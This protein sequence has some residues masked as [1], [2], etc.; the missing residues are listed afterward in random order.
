MANIL[1]V[2]DEPI[3]AWSIREALEAA[4]HTVVNEVISGAQ[5]IQAAHQ[6]K[7]DVVLMDIRLSD[8]VDGV[9]AARTIFATL[10]IPV[11]FLTAY[12]DD[13]TIQ[14]AL[15]TAPFGYVVKPF[16]RRELQASIKIAL[17][18]HQ[19]E[20]SLTAANHQLTT[21]LD[22]LGDAVITVDLEGRVTF[23][24]PVAEALTQ[25]PQPEALGLAIEQ[26]LPLFDQQR[27]PIQN[28]LRVALDSNQTQHLPDNC[29]LKTRKGQF[30]YVGDSA[31]AI[32][33]DAGQI[34]GGVLILQDVTEHKRV[35]QELHRLYEKSQRQ[36]QQAKLLNQ[37]VHTIRTSL[38][39]S[40]ILQQTVTSVLEAFRASRCVIRLGSPLVGYFTNSVHV[41]SPG[42]DSLPDQIMPMGNNPM[43]E[44]LFATDRAIAIGDVMVD[45]NLEPLQSYFVRSQIR[46]VL[47]VAIRFQR[48]IKGVICL[49]QCNA[50]R[51]WQADEI[52]LLEKVADQI[53]VAIDQAELYQ[54]LQK[55]NQELRR[56]AHLD[57]LTQVAN[58]T[59]FDQYFV[60]E[61]RRQRRQGTPLSLI[62][63]D[64]DHFKHY[65][66]TYGH[67]N[68]D[69][70]LRMVAKAIET[71]LK[72]PGDMV[73]RYGGEEFAIVLPNTDLDGSRVIAEA[74]QS[75][76][77]TLAIPHRNLPLST[78]VTVSMG[79]ASQDQINASRATDLIRAA[80]YALYQAKDQ[81]RNCYCVA[82]KV[83]G[84]ELHEQR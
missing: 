83:P 30:R 5:A 72:R 28:P 67:I 69:D 2:E 60:T 39:L 54:N 3:A 81:G 6:N 63:C 29:L 15:E 68:G 22:S 26:V 65:N 24:N 11:V 55:A 50:P 53:A 56:L 19:R 78:L 79:V 23:L 4:G 80:D 46:A 64:V 36:A 9:E 73:A 58:R 66:D 71:V 27:R 17:Q 59:A 82:T 84:Q 12:A 70:C 16:R 25:W 20:Q 74:I 47:A 44:R 14:Q 77:A 41:A 48:N 52:S 76:I 21:T 45:A 43:L 40:D 31:T 57:G 37:I 7:P 42:V 1:I 32:R 35:E 61:F 33:N 62:M 51:T 13:S 38:Q 8:D 34:L 49:H 75:A 10:K 18:R